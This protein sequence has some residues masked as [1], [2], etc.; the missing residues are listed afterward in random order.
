MLVG[1]RPYYARF[2][3]DV[4]RGVEMPPP[5]NPERVLG[6]RALTPGRLGRRDRAR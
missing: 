4:L 5:T 1:D 3:F 2:G 6:D